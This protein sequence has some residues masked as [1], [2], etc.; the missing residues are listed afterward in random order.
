MVL[1]GGQLDELV[2]MMDGHAQLVRAKVEGEIPTWFYNELIR[3]GEYMLT[4]SNPGLIEIMAAGSGK[5]A[6]V[7][8]LAQLLH[9]PRENVMACGDQYNDVGMIQWAGIGVAMGNAQPRVK[10]LADYV[11]PVYTDGGVA[12]AMERFVLAPSK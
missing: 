10:Q 1:H 4:S 7:K 5:R 8:Q 12:D 6:G 9:I 2:A 3:S 11:A